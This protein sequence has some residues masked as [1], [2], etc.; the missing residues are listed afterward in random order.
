SVRLTGFQIVGCQIAGCVADVAV[1]VVPTLCAHQNR[2]GY[3]KGNCYGVSGYFCHF[4]PQKIPNCQY[5]KSY[6]KTICPERTCK[7]VVAL[8][9]F[10]RRFVLVN[11][12]QYS[13]NKKQY[14]NFQK[15]FFLT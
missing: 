15:R 6:P 5:A 13:R 12:L 9:R 3:R 2:G 1:V 4:F 7:C 8:T 14:A 10:D 11:Q